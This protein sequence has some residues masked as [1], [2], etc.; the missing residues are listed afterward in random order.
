MQNKGERRTPPAPLLRRG[1]I[2]CTLLIEGEIVFALLFKKG[3][4]SDFPSYEE[5]IK[6]CSYHLC[7]IKAREEHPLA[8]SYEEGEIVFFCTPSYEGG[9]IVFALLFK[10]EKIISF[11]LF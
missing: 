10:K 4:Q 5:G 8:P 9:G 7:K 3:K 11:P 6:G 1:G 2:V